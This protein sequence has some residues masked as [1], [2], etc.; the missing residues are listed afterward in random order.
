MMAAIKL[1]D[2]Y[3]LEETYD[4]SRQRFK[5]QKYYFADKGET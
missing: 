4:K 1:K 2:T 3:F 5:K